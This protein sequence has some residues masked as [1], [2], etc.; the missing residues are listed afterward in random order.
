MG[1][2]IGA[3]SGAVPIPLDWDRA[4]QAWPVTVV[5]GAYLGWAGGREVGK[6]VAGRWR[7]SWETEK[8]K[9]YEGKTVQWQR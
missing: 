5:V 2:M 4:W 3:W 8:D 6:C 9:E 1:T 7:A